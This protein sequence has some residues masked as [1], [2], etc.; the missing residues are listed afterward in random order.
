MTKEQQDLIVSTVECYISGVKDEMWREI[1]D[2]MNPDEF[3]KVYDIVIG[4][5]DD[6]S[7]R[8]DDDLNDNVN[9]LGEEQNDVPVS[10][11]VR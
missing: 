1:Y 2:A 9:S 11:D 5:L 4:H 10:A 6:A 7:I 3:Q 8:I